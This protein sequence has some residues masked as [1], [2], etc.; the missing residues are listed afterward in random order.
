MVYMS[1][2]FDDGYVDHHKVAEELYKRDLPAT[3]FIITG[4]E[5][6]HGRRLLTSR[7]DRIRQIHDMGHEIAS[8]TTTHRNLTRLPPELVERECVESKRRLED[9]IG[10][11]VRGLAYPYGAFDES[12]VSVVRRYYQYARTV[13]Q[14]NMWN[15]TLQRYGIGSIG[16]KEL[17][18]HPLKSLSPETKL[19]V[20][21]LHYKNHMLVRILAEALKTMNFKITTITEALRALTCATQ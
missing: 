3:L 19:V 13:G 17:V 20:L 4:L 16:M 7:Q 10:D 6:F 15:E 14:W 5:E 2:T 12:V 11:E 9:I 21:T 18:K 1:I 8:H